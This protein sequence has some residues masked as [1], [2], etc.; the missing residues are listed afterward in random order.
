MIRKAHLKNLLI[1]FQMTFWIGYVS[2]QKTTLPAELYNSTSIPD[3][4]KE[5]ANSVI[6]YSERDILVKSAGKA[7]I[8]EHLIQT[9]LNEKDESEAVFRIYYDRKFSDINTAE[10]RIYDSKGALIKRYKKSDFYDR[11]A[12][13]GM[14]IITDS[15]LIVVGH[16]IVNYP[17]TVEKI[18]EITLNSFLDLFDW[19]IQQNEASVQFTKCKVSVK[20]SVGFRYQLK[21]FRLLPTK[22]QEGEYETYSWE[23]KNLKAIKPEE[24]S[25][26]WS[27]LP[28]ISFATNVIDFDDLPGDMSTWKGY[29]DWQYTLNKNSTTLPAKRIEEIKQMV[30]GLSSDK[31]KAK[32]LYEYLQKNTRYVS[33]QLGIGGLK[34]FPASFVDEKKYGDCKALSNYM[35]ALLS[36][37]DIPSYYAMVNAGANSEPADPKFV[38]DPFNHVIL[39]IPF[40]NDT[41]WLECT[42]STAPFGKLGSSTENRNALLVTDNGGELVNTPQSIKSDYTFDT[43]A[44]VTIAADGSAKAKLN[45]KTSGDYRDMMIQISK[46]KT[47][48]QKKFLIR[49]LNI[50]QPD[51]L[52]VTQKSDNNGVKELELDMEYGKLS[53]IAAGGKHFYRPRLFDLWRLTT[54][55]LVHRK[56]DF[57]FEHPMEKRCR[58]VYLLPADMDVESLPTDVSLNFS[59]GKYSV[60]Y[61][62]DKEKNEIQTLAEFEISKHVIPAAKYNEMQKFM[63]EIA[64]SMNKKMVLRKKG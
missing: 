19:H 9:I 39:C 54:P 30:S 42:S 24:D 32:F 43:D 37:V 13:D 64:K 40:K 5:N 29:G 50:K 18:Q 47:D 57:Y 56:T 17:I 20:P 27:F 8:K 10:M 14:S 53:D 1:V 33:I 7:V 35:K 6:R 48:E 44:K 58:T 16:T 52:E 38:N 41:T 15:R 12:V 21:N 61:M 23:V 25:E 28:R 3:S 46:D 11:S 45:I 31:D 49:Y 51:N 34:P 22:N 63:D 55:A 26:S 36:C 2:A 62:F 4:L 59:H 60:K